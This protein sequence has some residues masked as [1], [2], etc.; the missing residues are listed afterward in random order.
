[1]LEALEGCWDAH[2]VEGLDVEERYMGEARS[3]WSSSTRMAIRRVSRIKEVYFVHSVDA[4]R[5]TFF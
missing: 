1:M 3:K 4:E 2:F 5:P